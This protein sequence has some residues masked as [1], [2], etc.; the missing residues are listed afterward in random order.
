MARVAR[1]VVVNDV[2][3][4]PAMEMPRAY[5]LHAL[6]YGPIDSAPAKAECPCAMDER[7]NDPGAGTA[8]IARLYRAWQEVRSPLVLDMRSYWLGKCGT[9]ALP[10]PADIDPTEIPNLL[11]SIVMAEYAGDP[12][13]VRYRLVGTLQVFQNGL[14]FTGL[15]LDELDWGT[16]NHFVRD[17]HARI[18]A[19]AAPVFGAYEWDLRDSGRGLVEF[20]SFPLSEDGRHVTRC[21]TIDDFQPQRR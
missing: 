19:T 21:L 11:P 4:A 12:A 17:I 6:R 16:Y 1:P 5:G 9:R 8:Q 15:T 13:R 7:A 2:A 10:T 20:G 14:D 3:A 18:R